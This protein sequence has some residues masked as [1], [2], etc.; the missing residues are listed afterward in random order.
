MCITGILH[1]Y[2]MGFYFLELHQ[3]WATM[4]YHTTGFYFSTLQDFTFLYYGLA[5]WLVNKIQYNTIQYNLI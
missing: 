5:D 2:Y 3:I 1:M 4:S